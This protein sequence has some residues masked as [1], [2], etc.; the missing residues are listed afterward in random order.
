[1]ILF[2]YGILRFTVVSLRWLMASKENSKSDKIPESPER[3]S[4]SSSSE[5]VLKPSSHD[6]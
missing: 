1:M 3:K 5:N 4:S 6:S 2:M